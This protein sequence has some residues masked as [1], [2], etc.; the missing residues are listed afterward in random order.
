MQVI[1]LLYHRIRQG[2]DARRLVVTGDG[3]VHIVSVITVVRGQPEEVRGAAS[4]VIQ[5]G[6]ESGWK[7]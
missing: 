1:V 5:I 7:G 6:E 3:P 2:T 4:Y